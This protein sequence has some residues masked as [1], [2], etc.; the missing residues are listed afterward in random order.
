MGVHS[1]TILTIADNQ[2]IVNNCFLDKC[3]APSP[4][5]EGG[6]GANPALFFDV[7]YLIV[8]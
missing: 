7:I 6:N 1:L 4:H 3:V 2:F 5:F 8:E